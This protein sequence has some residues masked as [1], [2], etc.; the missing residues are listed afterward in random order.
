[1]NDQPLKG[2]QDDYGSGW[3]NIDYPKGTLVWDEIT[4]QF[5]VQ[6][7]QD[8]HQIKVTDKQHYWAQGESACLSD[9]MLPGLI[10]H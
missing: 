7:V 2:E 9:M 4:G 1:M 6:V 5:S 8:A 10:R 3:Y